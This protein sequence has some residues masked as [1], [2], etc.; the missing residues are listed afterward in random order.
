M[1]KSTITLIAYAAASLAAVAAA[2]FILAI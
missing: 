2:V 1:K